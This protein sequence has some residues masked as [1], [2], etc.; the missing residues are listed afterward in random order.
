[1]R[2]PGDSGDTFNKISGGIV[3]GPAILGKQISLTLPPQVPTALAGLPEV[4][5]VFTG[6]DAPLQELLD[7]LAPGH[8]DG[9]QPVLVRSVAGLA[10]IGKTELVAQAA[11]QAL[12]QTGWFPG[13]MLFTDLSGYHP[14]LRV[15]PE[16]ALDGWLRA[17]GIPGE[18]I[19]EGLTNRQ[20]LYRSVLAEFARQGQRILVII[21]N[22]SSAD[23]ARPLLPT[24]GLNAALVTSR[25]TLDLGARLLDLPILDESAAIALLAQVLHRAHG[26]RDTRVA[27]DP[28]AAQGIARLCA[29]LPLALRIIAALLAD[30][31]TRPLADISEDLQAEHS[32]LD[33]MEREER[34][35]RA[36]FDL[37]YQFLDEDHARLFRLLPLNPGPDVSTEAAAH[38]A[39]TAPR[40]VKK[41]IQ[42]LARAHLVEPRQPWGR[43]GLHDL[44]RLYADEQGRTHDTPDQ[45]HA[46][47]ARLFTHYQISTAAA[48]THLN[49]LPGPRSPRF[50]DRNQALQWLD[51]ERTSLI[52]TATTAPTL[53]YPDTAH[54][55][56]SLARY[57]GYRRQFDDWITI[58]TTAV[59]LFRSCSDRQREAGA[60]NNLGFALRE[61]RRFEEA[62]DA[63]THATELFRALTDQHGEAGALNGL[64][65]ALQEVRRFEEAIDAHTRAG[66]MH[67]GLGDRH[68]EAG[69]LNGLGL[70]LQEVR[71]FEE[72]IDAHTR[73]TTVFGGLGDRQGEAS[74]LDYLGLALREVRRFEEAIDAHTRAA[75]IH[76][77]LGD[78]HGEAR[79]LDHLG[80]ALREVRRFEEAITAHTH[81]TDLFRALAD[82]H[83]EAGALNNL[84]LALR[85]V[86][87][88]E[89]AIT[90]H[91]RAADIHRDLD[92]RHSEATALN[93]LGLALHQVRRFE[94]AIDA[95]TRATTVF[96]G[97][98]DRHGEASALNNLGFDLR[99]VRRLEEAIDA[100]TR[101][102][103]M[104]RGLGDRHGEAGALNNLGLDLRQVRRFEE[105]IDAHAHAADLFRAAVDR[106][107]EANTLENLGRALYSVRRFDE[108]AT[109][110]SQAVDTYRQFAADGRSGHGSELALSLLLL[111]VV[112]VDMDEGRVL[113]GTLPA[114]QEAA[115]L[116]GQ[117]AKDHAAEV[118]DLHRAA[119]EQLAGVLGLLGRVQEA[120]QVRRRLADMDPPAE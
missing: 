109:A 2:P 31:P 91:T 27:D 81:A 26:D 65:L 93:N 32:R 64:G 117:L 95:H 10:G 59:T 24:D 75:D 116:F 107:G 43:W 11:A 78:Q 52:A 72:A 110:V 106:H 23:Q 56:F 40:H 58:T 16:T 76:R 103:D 53:G 63:Y 13:G 8:A 77:G 5:P 46:A 6:R 4:S 118:T 102:G 114:A 55:A 115:E 92:D 68:G 104:H 113:P 18:Y 82:Q 15:P 45:R 120:E 41:I 22:A 48:D 54:L 17:L 60:L 69:A 101:A 86:R 99:Q 7:G 119:L 37:S 94:E 49:T 33:G 79:A 85:Q 89:E 73:A 84:G 70:A 3:I 35:V 57:L 96:G 28:Q 47:Q 100:H 71:R 12:T 38:L 1:M 34:A 42:D 88:F 74:A 83:G 80:L 97:L 51:A 44:V 90:A 111:A 66:D 36:A 105:A 61:A 67:R 98:G 25:H 39:D 30:A 9:Q 19:P 62:I 112:G 87:R 108:A 29:G 14:K 21:D 20:G 50:Q